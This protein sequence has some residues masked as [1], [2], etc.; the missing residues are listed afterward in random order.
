MHAGH[1]A[2]HN[3]TLN[4]YAVNGNYFYGLLFGLM[5]GSTSFFFLGGGTVYLGVAPLDEFDGMF[6]GWGGNFSAV[7]GSLEV[8]KLSRLLLEF[9]AGALAARSLG[10]EKHEF[11][12][13]GREAGM[14]CAGVPFG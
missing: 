11:L 4:R 6:P 8:A 10:L 2:L 12:L 9:L 1:C 14:F 3:A 5:N 13:K 7:G